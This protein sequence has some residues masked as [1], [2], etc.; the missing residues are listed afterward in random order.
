MR[1]YTIFN[2]EGKILRRGF[3]ATAAFEEKAGDGEF[4]IEGI[5]DD[6]TQ[7]IE[8][9]GFDVNGQPINP[10]VVDKTPEEM[11]GIKIPKKKSKSLSFGKQSAY[12]TNE[13]W[14]DVLDRLKKLEAEA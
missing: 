12:I 3:C 7:K 6:V 9:D 13:L 8:F 11:K 5:G 1:K 2:S 4:V 10:R 14:Q